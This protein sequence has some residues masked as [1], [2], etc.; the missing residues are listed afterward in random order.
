MTMMRR[1]MAGLIAAAA[2]LGL[3]ALPATAQ[4]S[5]PDRPIH[6]VIGFPAG[7]GADIL[8]RYFAHALEVLAKQPVVV[9][10]KPGATSNIAVRA[11]AEAKPDG[12]TILFVANSNMA[13]SRYLFKDLPFDT[14]KDFVPIASFAQITFVM[15]VGPTSPMNNLQDM[16]KHLKAKKDALYGYTNQTAQL[17]SEYYKQLAGVEAKPVAY[18]SAGDTMRD[19][20]DATLDFVIMDGTFASGQIKQGALKPI[21]VTT[22]ERFPSWPDTPT[23]EQAGLANYEFA[24]WWGAYLPKGTPQ[25]IVDKLQAMFLQIDNMKETADFLLTV[26][27][28][29]THDDSKGADARLKAELPKWEKLVKAAGIEPQ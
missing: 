12:Y 27:A 22:K 15:V 26:G 21:A 1:T 25:P 24:P 14:L 8:G 5:F 29:P 23:I 19:L 20:S 2:G 10:N 6:A 9:D 18:K 16:T 3:F 17:A 13:G 4:N 7:S 28:F 11:V